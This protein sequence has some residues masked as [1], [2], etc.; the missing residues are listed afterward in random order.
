VIRVFVAAAGLLIGAFLGGALL[1]LNPVT[2]LQREPGPLPEPVQTLGWQAGGGHSGM[3]L[4]PG[5]LLGDVP[6]DGPGFEDP[7]IR[8]ARIEVVPLTDETGAP[9]ALGVRLA[10]LSRVNAL[11]AGRLGL[12][13][14]WNVVWPGRGTLALAGSENF[15]QP[16][17]DALWSAVRGRG[18]R[19]GR[20]RY[21]LPALPGGAPLVVGG[22]GEFAGAS[23]TF[24]EEFAPAEARPDEFTGLRQL[25]LSLEER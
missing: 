6:G 20:P 22:T 3:P 16:L 8:H 25:Q 23:G 5:G 2:F 21:L 11:T 17:R 7:G 15:W 4:T 1:M 13:T 9:V 12:V 19:P 14:A 18:M 10:A 24:R